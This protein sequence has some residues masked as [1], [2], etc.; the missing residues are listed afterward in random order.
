MLFAYQYINHSMEKIQDFIDYIFYEVWCKAPTCTDY[1]FDLYNNKPEL[2][3]VVTAF[4]YSSTKEGDFFNA[5]I[6]EIFLIFKTLNPDEICQL[7]IWYLSNN[8]IK[9][10]CNNDPTVAPSTYSDV[11]QLNAG[12]GNALKIF[13]IRLYS[14]DLLSLKA[15]SDKIG[16]IDEHYKEFVKKNK[17]GK[18]PFCGLYDI[19]N[20]YVH[21]REAYD[22]YL[23]KS[24]YPFSSI[25]FKNLAP[26]CNKCNS[27]NKGTKDPLHD[28]DGN[29]RKSF[30]AYNSIPY[31]L[32]IGLTLNSNDIA[33]LTPQNITITFGPDSLA[34]ELKTWNEL[35]GIEERYKAKCCSADAK[36][37]ITQILDEDG[38]K[39]PIEFLSS[40]LA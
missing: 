33:N 8:N 29:R 13:F 37:W 36:Y 6:E 2:K 12:L 21:T 35:F 27:G 26:I 3:E 39:S 32:E 11:T 28:T 17:K 30:Y 4:H 23:P 9:G 19:D 7:K 38:E 24:K 31:T 25:N 20:E 14:K 5:K 18:C 16:L 34:E 15:L 40:R 22:H 10:L 1:S